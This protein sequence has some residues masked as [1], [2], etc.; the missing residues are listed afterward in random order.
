MAAIPYQDDFPS[1]K[2]YFGG[3]GGNFAKFGESWNDAVTDADFWEDASMESRENL[4]NF[5]LADY[6]NRFNTYQNELAYKRQKEMI[7]AENEYNS[8]KNQMARYMEGGLNPNVIY[9]QIQPGQQTQVA[10]YDP[11]RATEVR[12]KGDPRGTKEQKFAYAMQSLDMISNV[13]DKILGMVSGAE[14]VKSQTL[15]NDLLEAQLPMLKRLE[16]WKEGFW[17][18]PDMPT[19][20]AMEPHQRAMFN[21]AFPRFSASELA[22]YRSEF[23]K[24]YNENLLPKLEKI[25]G[26]NVT[27]AEAQAG[28]SEYNEQMLEKLR[29][30]HSSV[31]NS[32]RIIGDMLTCACGNH[33]TVT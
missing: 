33:V 6:N 21:L 13:A 10:Q 2:E 8:P 20:D 7:A 16:A 12:A 28:M 32:L 17:F 30:R 22:G 18:N 3:N 27:K 11:V 19:P 4:M 29:N 1:L 23:Q 5:F 14:S 9:G 25:Q 31:L 26:A 24:F 15:K